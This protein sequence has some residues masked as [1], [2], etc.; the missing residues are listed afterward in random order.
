MS[1]KKFLIGIAVVAI[2]IG[3]LV[4]IY[5]IFSQDGVIKGFINDSIKWVCDLFGVD[6]TVAPQF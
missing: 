6:A 2:C 1:F 3:I 4:I 5:G